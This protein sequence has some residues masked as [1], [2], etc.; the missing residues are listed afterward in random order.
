MRRLGLGA[1]AA[2]LACLVMMTVGLLG[3]PRASVI[4]WSVLGAATPGPSGPTQTAGPAGAGQVRGINAA[5]R[6][7]DL[8]PRE[9]G[10]V[11]PHGTATP[12]GDPIEIRALREVFGEAAERLH[13]S[14]TKSMHGH[15]LGAAGAMEAAITVLALAKRQI[16]PTA[17]LEQVSADCLGV[18]HVMGSGVSDA[19][20]RAALSNSFAFGGSNA[21]L[22]FR[23]AD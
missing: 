12:E 7:A 18:G 1:G 10:S 4:P 13:V 17:H 2:L 3:G 15:M 23:R 11:N 20:L 5:L 16:P 19:S 22:A 14:A 21:V 6:E 9:V 8:S